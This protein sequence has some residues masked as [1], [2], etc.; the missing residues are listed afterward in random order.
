M[1]K[2]RKS[3]NSAKRTGGS[4]AALTLGASVVAWLSVVPAALSNEVP[5]AS[6]RSEPS[7]MDIE[8]LEKIGVTV[9]QCAGPIVEVLAKSWRRETSDYRLA[10]R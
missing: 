9:F 5:A 1:S 7:P 8:R 2:S 3:K 10:P 6:E 4:L